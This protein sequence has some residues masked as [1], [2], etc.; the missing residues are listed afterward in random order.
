LRENYTP[1]SVGPMNLPASSRVNV[2][3]LAAL[4]A[5]TTNSYKFY[6]LLALLDSLAENGQPRIALRDLSLRMVAGV[7]YPLDYFKLSFGVDDGFKPIADFVSGHIQVDNR[8][9]AR[10]LFEQLGSGLA[11][12]EKLTLDRMVKMLLRF[13]PYRFLRPFFKAELRGL[14]DQ[15]VNGRIAEL[16]R[17]SDAAPYRLDGDSLDI[18]P[19]WLVYLQEHQG[20]LRGFT[21]WHLLRFLQKNNPNV[22]GLAE[23]LQPPGDNER[24]LKVA[25]AYWK[26]FLAERPDF[27]CI[28]SGQPLTAGNLSIDHFLPWSYVA[29][30][31]LWNLVP[32][33]KPVNSA[34]NNWL[35]DLDLYFE[36]FARTQF[37]AFQFHA[38]KGNRRALE[39]YHL[40][41]AQSLDSIKAAPFEWF[42]ERLARQILPQHQTAQNMGFSF[43]FRYSAK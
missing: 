28:Y 22:I 15:Q 35:P 18:Y 16:S 37:E 10:P 12:A 14:P 17:L 24:N 32:A 21:Y 4:F 5:D 25:T 3:H 29:H 1:R 38:D 20:I 8:P 2:A 7:W 23:K 41:F 13:V 9:S 42:R 36:R 39:E 33:P 6:W 31:Q 30:N 40:L 11:T 27:R 43:P 19:N 26:A 34:K